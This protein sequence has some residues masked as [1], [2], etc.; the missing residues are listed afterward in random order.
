ME[1][2]FKETKAGENSGMTQINYGN[3]RGYQTTV[4]GGTAYIAEYIQVVEAE[5]KP[6]DPKTQ[7]EYRQKKVLLSKVKEYW[8]EGVLEKSLHS[9]AMIEL[10]L[11]KRLDAVERPFRFEELPEESKQK[12]STGISATDVFNQMG[13]GRTLLI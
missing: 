12:L 9:K 2:N 1:N 6:P 7:Q 5:R 3:S 11:E 8:I 13:E 10:G 4:N